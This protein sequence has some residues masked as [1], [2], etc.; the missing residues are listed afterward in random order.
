MQKYDQVQ[1]GFAERIVKMAEQQLNHRIECENKVVN[2]S[3]SDSKRGQWFGLTVSVLFLIAAT[4]LGLYG[5]DW[6][7]GI[8]GGGTLVS[9]V[10]IFVLN[11]RRNKEKDSE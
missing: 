2:G 7:A 11:E 1:P 5:H 9:L 6:L 3:V 8:L 10:S 4:V